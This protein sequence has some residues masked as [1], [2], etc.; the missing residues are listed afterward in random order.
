MKKLC[1]FLLF[2]VCINAY[3]NNFEVD[4]IYFKPSDIAD[5]RLDRIKQ[6]ITEA[7]IRYEEEM[8]R[9]GF[10]RRTF[11]LQRDARGEVI[12]NQVNG[13]NGWRN[14]LVDSWEKIKAEL[15]DRF[16]AYTAPFDKADR[17]QLIIVGGV[18]SVL[19]SGPPAAAGIGWPRHSYR[20]GGTALVAAGAH[21]DPDRTLKDVIFHELTHCFGL[22]HKPAGRDPYA[23][24]E[25]EARWLDKHYHFNHRHNNF[26]LPAANTQNAKL[27][28]IRPDNIKIEIAATAELGLHQAVLYRR[29]DIMLIGHDYLN[30]ERTDIISI[31]AHRRAWGNEL[32]FALM[33]NDGNHIQKTIN[34]R[35]PSQN[36][37]PL[38]NN[39]PK[40][41][42]LAGDAQQRQND[43]RNTERDA[44]VNSSFKLTTQWAK[45]KKQ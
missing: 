3:A 43:N 21:F 35:L 9:Y 17:I 28:A 42:D 29:S 11:R 40:N 20:Y 5:H 41:P 30:S 6:A 36:E 38:A 15:P 26:T 31:Q 19:K 32:L 4:A 13:A 44:S 25:Y 34:V 37:I 1:L 23:L 7:Q 24:D 12:L 22:Y 27:T 18:A 8:H 39:D 16:N 33:D 2:S 10:G 45:L 14:Y